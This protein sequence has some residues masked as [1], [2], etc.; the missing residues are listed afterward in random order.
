M[1]LLFKTSFANCDVIFFPYHYAFLCYSAEFITSLE[2]ATKPKVTTNIWAGVGTVS[3]FLFLDKPTVGLEIAIEKR[4]YFK[5]ENFKNF[6]LSG[7]LGAAYMTDLKDIANIG[8]VPGLKLSHKTHVSQ[9]LIF[10]PYIS[11][12]VPISY[13]FLESTGYVPL[14]V[15]TVGVRFGLSKIIKEIKS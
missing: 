11:L 12:S 2:I 6:S 14:P 3:S 4:R 15:L 8:V 10:E 9:K 7:Y 5:T 13:D 1:I